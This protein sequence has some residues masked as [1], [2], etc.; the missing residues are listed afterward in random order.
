MELFTVCVEGI[1]KS[2]TKFKLTT[3]IKTLSWYHPPMAIYS[4][5]PTLQGV[6]VS[7][8]IT[9]PTCHHK[10]GCLDQP[11]AAVAGRHRTRQCDAGKRHLLRHA[12][13]KA[14]YQGQVGI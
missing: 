3:I 10:C 6:D 14:V 11:S 1:R 5:F 9:M 2:N 7:G 12:Q 13:Y 8:H 4:P